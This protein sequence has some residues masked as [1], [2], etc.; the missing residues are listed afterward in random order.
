[1]SD[2]FYPKND[3]ILAEVLSAYD[4]PATLLGA[5]RYGQGHINDTFCVLCQPQEG[6]CIRFILQGLSSAAFPHPE[7]LMENFVG[8]TSYLRN[9]VIAAGGDHT[10]ETLS[11]VTTKDGKDFYTDSN[12][13]AWRLTPFIENTDCF[14]SATPELFEASARAFGRFQYMLQGYPAETLHETIVNFHNTEDRFAK[15]EAALAADKHDRAKDI[16]AEIQFVLDRKADCSVALQA[17]RDGKLP[18]R[19]THNDTKLNNILID[20]DTHE[21]ICVI[22]LDTTM[23]GL[24]IN[25]FGDSIRFG[26]NHSAEDEKDISKVSVD[27]ELYRTYI[28]G[29]LSSCPELTE[30]ELMSL[31]WGARTMTLEC[32]LRFLTDYLDG[33]NYFAVHRPG[34]NL[35]RCRTQLKMVQDMEAKWEEMLSIITEER[36]KL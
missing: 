24:S 7:E 34:H 19:V 35:D 26:A 29:F 10:R 14:Q 21:G 20:R 16:Q 1:M 11:L 32:G 33:D 6:D 18:L 23:P 31:P 22:D 15:F 13:K 12:G 28:R 27:L 30:D 9:K 36:A 25:D 5:V 3:P 4:F 17:L 2:V 8:I